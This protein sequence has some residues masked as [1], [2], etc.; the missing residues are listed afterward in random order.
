M[1]R[2]QTLS[3]LSN[4]P[5]QPSKHFSGDGVHFVQN[6]D[7]PF[8]RGEPFHESLGLPT[9]T[10][11]VSDHA[12]RRNADA[13]VVRFVLG[14]GGETTDLTVISRAPHLKLERVKKICAIIPYSSP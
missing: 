4:P 10:L 14:V 9:T 13:R 5:H 1:N 2:I 6:H 3:P 12:V 7:A 8:L 11:R